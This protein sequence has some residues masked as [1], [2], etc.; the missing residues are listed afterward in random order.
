MT[1]CHVSRFS[2]TVFPISHRVASHRTRLLLGVA[3]AL[4]ALCS[5]P[6]SLVFSLQTHP[7][8]QSYKQC[9]NTITFTNK[10]LEL[11]YFL[12]FFSLSWLLPILVMTFCYV[13]IIVTICRRLSFQCTPAA[14]TGGECPRVYDKTNIEDPVLK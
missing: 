4:A 3:W 2:A 1:T 9:L 13:S 11:A 5:I 12:Y 7:V 6:Q 8:V 10:K 14:S